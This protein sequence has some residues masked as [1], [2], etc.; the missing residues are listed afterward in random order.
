MKSLLMVTA[1][2]A[3]IA[4]C[5][6]PAASGAQEVCDTLAGAKIIAQDEESTYLGTVSS[7]SDRDSIFNEYGTYG[8]DYSSESLWN[9]Y[10]KFGSEYNRT[11][12]F[13]KYSSSPPMLIR[14]RDVIG[15]LSENKSNAPSISPARLKTLCKD[16]Y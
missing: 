3:I 1:K 5:L 6:L 13:N 14:G 10:S 15:Y 9:R 2:A 11:S 16:A 7:S 4:A 12:P 8:N